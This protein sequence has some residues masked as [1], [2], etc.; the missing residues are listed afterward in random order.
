MKWKKRGHIYSPSGSLWWAKSYAM[1]PTAEVLERSVRVYF[2]SLD[3]NMFGRIGSIELDPEDLTNILDHPVEPVLDIGELGTFD[4][5]GVN[6]SSIISYNSLKYLYYIGWQRT[7]RVPY[8]L[9]SGLAISKDNGRTF[10]KAGRI[11]VL[12]RTDDEPFSRSAPFVLYE[13]GIFRVWYWSCIKWSVDENIKDN[14]NAVHYNNVIRYAESGDGINWI[15]HDENCIDLSDKDE[16]SVGRPCV[17]NDN[18]LYR[19]WYSIRSK[20]K[21]YAIGY[22]ESKDGVKWVRRDDEAG[23]ERSADGGWD[24]EMICYPFV[25]DINGR[26]V[27]FYNGNRH[28]KTGFGYAELEK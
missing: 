27:M 9:F 22:A 3:E 19:M 23:I 13:N 17:I 11:P 25:I 16:Y 28:G 10:E 18:G 21:P 5:S 2:A 20:T 8:M 14:A 12:D 4:D 15:A 24:S 6:A 1:I 7:Q 26:R